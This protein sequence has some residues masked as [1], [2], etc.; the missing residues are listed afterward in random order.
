VAEEG[1]TCPTC[2]EPLAADATS[3]P[4]CSILETVPGAPS[5]AARAAAAA[6]TAA[7]DA[8]DVRWRARIDR[9]RI[10]SEAGPTLGVTVPEFPAWAEEFARDRSDRARWEAAL[11]EIEAEAR[12]QILASVETRLHDIEAR[13]EKLQAYAV[14]SRLESEGARDALAALARGDPEELIGAYRQLDRVVSLKERHI[15]QARADLTEVSTLLSEIR[16]L[17]LGDVPDPSEIEAQ[18][19]EELRK[20][21][22]VPLKQWLR[23]VRSEA[24]A[25]A[26]AV[27]PDR[28]REV[29][30]SLGAARSRGEDV[31]DEVSALA[32]AARSFANGQTEVG[33]H[34]LNRIALAHQANGSDASTPTP[35]GAKRRA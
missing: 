16:S 30:R 28:V 15:E 2:G 19:D 32:R 35:T 29:G 10:W 26:Q 27:G 14:E 5:E 21:K 1:R 7:N 12:K 9:L 34:A 17:E 23:R 20:G 22:L 8:A 33:V 6:K 11:T 18:F 31:A 13:I 3:C 4:V 24:D 25:A